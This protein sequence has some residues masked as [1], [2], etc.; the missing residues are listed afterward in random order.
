MVKSYDKN[1]KNIFEGPEDDG[2]KNEQHLM[3]Y[4]LLLPFH[5]IGFLC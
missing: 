1:Q 3:K 4:I 5:K 2:L